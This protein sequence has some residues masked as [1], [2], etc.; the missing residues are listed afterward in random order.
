MPTK[1]KTEASTPKTKAEKPEAKTTS[2]AEKPEAKTTSKAKKPEAKTTSKAKKPDAKTASKAEKP[3]AKEPAKKLE[4]YQFWCVSHKCA[5][6][7]DKNNIKLCVF[8][9]CRVEKGTPA[10]T[11]VCN[12]M[13]TKTVE[14][15][16]VEVECG[17]SL[18]KFISWALLEELKDSGEYGEPVMFPPKKN[19]AAPKKKAAD[20]KKKPEPDEDEQ[21]EPDE[22]EPD[23]DEQDE[24]EDEELT[25]DE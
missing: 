8:S 18:A 10:M 7:P 2:K 13:K 19:K 11:G 22:D 1:K 3:E 16:E 21:D 4:R 5:V 20:T 25:E 24:D 17:S 6:S 23:K 15:K 12:E 9:N 14:G